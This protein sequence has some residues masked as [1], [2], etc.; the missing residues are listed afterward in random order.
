M[1]EFF[2]Q[3]GWFLLGLIATIVMTIAGI[4]ITAIVEWHLEH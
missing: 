4:V 1:K 3:A 2:K